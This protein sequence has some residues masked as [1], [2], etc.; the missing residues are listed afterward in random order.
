L[1]NPTVSTYPSNSEFDKKRKRGYSF[2]MSAFNIVIAFSALGAYLVQ[3]NV[4]Y[5]FT[6]N[7]NSFNNTLL[8]SI[9][10]FIS[11]FSLEIT[12][13]AMK[14]AP[15]WLRGGFVSFLFAVCMAGFL[16]VVFRS[17]YFTPPICNGRGTPNTAADLS[18]ILSCLDLNDLT[19]DDMALF[20]TNL[21]FLAHT[22]S[23]IRISNN[24]N[25]EIISFPFANDAQDWT[26]ESNN[27]LQA[28]SA[29]LFG[30][31]S[32]S[33]GNL[34]LLN[35][36]KLVDVD[37]PMLSDIYDH[38]QVTISGNDALASLNFPN[39]IYITGVMTISDNDN[40]QNVTFDLLP[41]A[42][43][44]ISISNNPNLQTI[45]FPSWRSTPFP[46]GSFP[47]NHPNLTITYKGS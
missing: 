31:S 25:I 45:A 38:S 5:L 10:L 26:I 20:K 6:L 2:M 36:P 4:K 12:S 8:A 9:V 47:N 21:T 16:P 42:N 27:N 1:M 39:I 19:I 41:S 22:A 14:R 15:S 18:E 43:G 40:L 23:S 34:F 35:N 7:D 13:F 37:F 46:A 32:Y 33:F 30:S 28:I 29:P 44:I 17:I 3:L 11:L 24:Q